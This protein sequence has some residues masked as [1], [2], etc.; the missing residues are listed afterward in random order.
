MHY[1]RTTLVR[2]FCVGCTAVL[3]LVPA[4][5]TGL[6]SARRQP[7]ALEGS[8]I[9]GGGAVKTADGTIV[10]QIRFG[11]GAF[12][13]AASPEARRRFRNVLAGMAIAY[14]LRGGR[15]IEGRVETI[16]AGTETMVRQ[17]VLA[18]LAVLSV[19]SGLALGLGGRNRAAL[20]AGGFLAGLGATLGFR[21][22]EP[23]VVLIASEPLRDAVIMA[24]VI[25]PA[26]LWCRFLLQLAAELPVALRIS[27]IQQTLIEGVSIV[28]VVRSVLLAWSQCG[29]LFDHL[30][31]AFTGAI[32]RLLDSGALQ[33][34]PYLATALLGIAFIARQARAMRSRDFGEAGERARIAGWGC[35]AGVGIP[36][37]AAALQA[38]SLVVSGGLLVPRE[39]MALLLL[40]VALV[41][42]SLSYALLARRVERPGVVAQRAIVF[43]VADGALL[44]LAVA[45]LGWLAFYLYRHFDER[46]AAHA[47]TLVTLVSVTVLSLGMV[48]PLR[49]SLRRLFFRKTGGAAI[50]SAGVVRAIR[51]ASDT[52]ALAAALASGIDRAV[53][54]ESVALFVHDTERSIL[55][56]PVNRLAPLSLTSRI[57][58]A[59]GPIDISAAASPAGAEH[60]WAEQRSFRLLLPLRGSGDALLGV[61]AVGEAMSGLPLNDEE[62]AILDAVATSTALML[63]NLTLRSAAAP[64]QGDAGPLRALICPSCGRLFD[65]LAAVRCDVDAMPLAPATVPRLLHGKFRL[66]QRIGAGSMSVIYRAHDLALGRDVAIKTLPPLSPEMTG[67][68]ER[69]ASAAAALAHPSIATIHAFETW[70]GR[71][72]LV[73]E[74]LEGGTLAEEIARGAL[75]PHRVVE[76]GAALAAALEH[77]HSAGVLHRDVKPSN[78]GFS[79]DG[80]PKLIDFGL[81]VRSDGATA[82]AG[83]PLYLSPEAILGSAASESD[84][85]WSLAL[86]LYEALTGR[87]PFAAPTATLVMNAIL[88][89]HLPDPRAFRSAI[90]QHVAEIFMRALARD[91]SA[92]L[93]TA[94]DLRHSLIGIEPTTVSARPP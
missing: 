24:F 19:V 47:A 51:D 65:P 70:H 6:T 76:I 57:V 39:V 86:T 4:A 85:V 21:L 68:L 75:D 29:A 27:R 56:D 15:V 87:N 48:V 59:R 66:D 62:R 34:L 20:S 93:R 90:P 69:E 80:T 25:V 37:A 61:I 9:I 88:G 92:R 7:V 82:L 31:A 91:P 35:A 16:A 10:E 58:S 18:F 36:I 30:P 28:A 71:P 55:A 45:P 84:D 83:T 73:F 67:R 22:L 41:P 33:L 54:V 44:L 43:A 94:R 72:M 38:G 46:L 42:L 53:P 23:N 89:R 3:P 32:L 78:V 17:L 79:R 26:G 8:Q 60:A 13:R 74:L 77:A 14:R 50:A 63:E 81:A 12:Q 64:R 5:V 11:G 52:A 1:R 40:P 49:R 2:L